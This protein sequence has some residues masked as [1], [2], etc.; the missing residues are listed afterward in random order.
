MHT[1]NVLY[2]GSKSGSR[3]KLL[4]EAQIPFK[5]VEQNADE[6]VCDWGLSLQKIV[7]RIAVYKMEQVVLPQGV[8]GEQ[9]F[10]LTADTLSC[11]S[12]GAIHG[13]P[14]NREDAIKKIKAGRNGTRIGTAFCLDK[15]VYHLGQW[16]VD[17]RIL[18]FVDAEY[19]FFV[20]DIWID[21]Y[22]EKSLGLIASGALAVELFGAQFLKSI[23]GSYTTIVGLPM[24][25][26]REALYELGFWDSK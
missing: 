10:V 13:K 6:T 22:L 19:L 14:C 20:P 25:E 17:R 26:L 8:E 3:Q 1:D 21:T 15:K 24:F 5:V 7:E 9:C 11:D 23:N 2:L 4:K 16:E 12:T 18:S